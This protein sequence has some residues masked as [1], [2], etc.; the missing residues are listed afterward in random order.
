[1]KVVE[2]EE[3][4]SMPEPD[5]ET[6]YRTGPPD[7][8]YYPPQ[9]RETNWPAVF[10]TLVTLLICLLGYAT[11]IL[12]DIKAEVRKT[13]DQQIRD[14]TAY[15]TERDEIKRR[16]TTA[17]NKIDTVVMAFQYNV[18]GRLSYLESKTG[19]KASKESLQPPAQPTL[20]GD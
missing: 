8:R 12:S 9:P 4:N 2:R 7:R 19:F 3:E 16:I 5:V 17:E 20:Q 1:M 18:N 14:S 13:S 11:T 15:S 10:A 6:D